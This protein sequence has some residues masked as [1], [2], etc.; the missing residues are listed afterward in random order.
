VFVRPTAPGE[1]VGVGRPTPLADR[2]LEEL[3]LKAAERASIVGPTT[4]VVYAHSDALI[5]QL[6]ADYELDYVVNG[7]FIDGPAGPRMLAELIRASDGAHVWVEAYQGVA[8][9]GRV[10]PEIAGAV[11]ARLGLTD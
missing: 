7:R 10:G 5:A 3:T 8:D 1:S 6:V 9:A 4:T 2:I 11:L